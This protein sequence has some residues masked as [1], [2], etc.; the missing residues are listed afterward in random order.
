MQFRATNDTKE[1]HPA[2]IQLAICTHKLK[3]EQHMLCLGRRVGESIY[4]ADNIFI[5]VLEFQKN[6][7]KIGITAPREVSIHRLEI[8]EKIQREADNREKRNAD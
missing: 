1:K 8:Y 2:D 7:V 5:T 3:K 4:I 6:Q